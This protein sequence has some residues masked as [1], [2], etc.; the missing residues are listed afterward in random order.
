MTDELNESESVDYD[1]DRLAS[2]PEYRD[3]I[4][5]DIA[6]TSS[7]TTK[8]DVTG[9]LL[10]FVFSLVLFT[11]GIFLGGKLGEHYAFYTALFLSCLV[12]FPVFAFL[13]YYRQEA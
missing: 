1:K 9:W 10:Y 3:K 5:Q 6:R 11:A 8:T 12:I 13:L 7:S 2:D 4:L